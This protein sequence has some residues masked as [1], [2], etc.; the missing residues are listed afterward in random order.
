M[1]VAP[2]CHGMATHSFLRAYPVNAHAYY[3]LSWSARVY[4]VDTHKLAS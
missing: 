2:T 4:P 3:I 1:R